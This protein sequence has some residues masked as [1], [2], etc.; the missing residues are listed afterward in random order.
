MKHVLLLLLF[1][2]RPGIVYPYHRGET[3]PA[4]LSLYSKTKRISR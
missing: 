3:D 2:F 1:T 4:T